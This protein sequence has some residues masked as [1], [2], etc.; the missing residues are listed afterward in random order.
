MKK[1]THNFN[2]EKKNHNFVSYVITIFNKRNYLLNVINAL[3]KEGGSQKKEFIIVDD[4]STDNTCNILKVLEKKI[5]GRVKIIKRANMGASFSTNEAVKHASG[6]WIRL[7]DGDDLVAYKSTEK[8][9]TLARKYNI[10]FVYGKI[11][12]KINKVDNKILNFGELQNSY[13]GLS[14]FIRNCPANSSAIFVS[15]KRFLLSG[16]CDESFISPDQVLFLRLF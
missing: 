4:G 16:G 14:K 6:Y 1:I 11:S 7:L 13:T 9:L 5:P 2:I 8:M 10:D 12:K 3:Q 15:K